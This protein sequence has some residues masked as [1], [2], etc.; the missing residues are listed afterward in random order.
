[1]PTTYYRITARSLTRSETQQELDLTEAP[2]QDINYARQRAVSY[3]ERLNQQ[4][5]LHAT[6]WVG[7]AEP[8]TVN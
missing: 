6:D 2:T 7:Y 4:Q 3:A 8:N 5:F 1:M